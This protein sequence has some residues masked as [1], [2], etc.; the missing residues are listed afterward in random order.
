MS[1][2]NTAKRR[3]I[4]QLEKDY[5]IKKKNKVQYKKKVKQLQFEIERDDKLIKDDRK[6]KAKEK[7]DIKNEVTQLFKSA[8]NIIK[9]TTKKSNTQRFNEYVNNL[10][11]V[12]GLNNRRRRIHLKGLGN[13]FKEIYITEKVNNKEVMRKVLFQ[14]VNKE[15]EEARNNNKTLM[16]YFEFKYFMIDDNGIETTRYSRN[17]LNDIPT[18]NSIE[19]IINE[20]YNKLS[21][22]L[23]IAKNNSRLQFS[24]ISKITIRTTR[25]QRRVGGDY[26]ESPEGVQN[27]TS[28]INIKNFDNR[29]LEYCILAS[30]H[31]NDV[32]VN[33]KR[34]PNV[35]KKYFNELNIPENQK[36]PIDIIED[37]PKYE[38]LNKLRIMIYCIRDK[39]FFPEYRS[40]S[41]HNETLNLLLLEEGDKKHFIW[42]RNITRI[43]NHLSF[44]KNHKR[45]DCDNCFAKS[46]K[47]QEKLD[48]HQKLCLNNKRC[49]VELPIKGK[50]EMKFIHDC[51][52]FKHPFDV[53]ADFES[54]LLKVNKRDDEKDEVEINDKKKKKKK[55]KATFAYQKHVPNSCGLKYNC[56]HDIHSEKIKIINDKNPQIVCDKWIYELERLAKKS[57]LLTQQHK[58]NI[59]WKEGEKEKHFKNSNC[60]RCKVQYTEKNKRV[61]HHNHITGDFLNSFC[62]ECNLKY[63]YKPFLP[64]YL[65]NLKGYDS[66]LFI[67]SL[68][69]CGYQQED[70]KDII[71][72]I[73][74]NEERYIS[75]SKKIKVVE[76]TKNNK[77]VPI[78]YEIRFIDTFAF[79]ASSIDALSDNLKKGCKS[80]NELR[81]VFKNISEEFDNDE[82]FNLIIKK[83]VY[84]YDYID[85]YERLNEDKLP[86]Q[87]NFYSKLNNQ[88]CNDD[89]YERAKLVWKTFKCK[90]LIDYHNVY[91]KSDVLLLSDIW[92]N[93]RE[94]CYK[95]Y[96]LDCTYY[97]TAPSLS[98]D[99]MM[100][101]TNIKFELLTDIDMVNFVES[102]IR[103]GLSQISKRHAEANN[104]YMKTYEK[105]KEDSYITYLDANNLY[106][107][108][109]SEYLPYKSFKWNKDIWTR[110]KILDLNDKGD[111]GY[112][113]AVDLHIPVKLHDYFNGYTPLP[114]NKSIKKKDLNEWQ[115][116]DYNETKVEKLCCSLEDRKDYVVNY[117]MLKLALSLGY[118][119]KN[120]N[121]VLEYEQ[122]PF[123]KEYIDL[124]TNLRTKA[125]NDF[126]KDF[127]KLMNNSV[128]GKTMENVKNRIEFRLLNNEGQVDRLQSKM[129]NFT[130]FDDN[131]VGVHLQKSKVV[132][133]KPIYIGQNVLDDSK[134]T[135]MNFHYNFMKKHIK[136]E[137]LSLLFTDTDSLCY[138][139]K[140][141]DIYEK[142]QNNKKYFDLSNYPK[143][144]FLYDETNKKVV[145]MF[146][147]E[148]IKEIKEFI[149]LRSKLYSY[150][151]DDEIE[152]KRCKGVKKS[153]VKKFI[154]H[155]NYKNTLFKRDDF[156]VS[157]NGIRSYNHQ[158]YSET[159]M[160]VALSA[161]DDKVYIENNNI[162]TLTHGHYKINNK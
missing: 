120:V 48:E 119:L 128:F 46:F 1:T 9:P 124:N 70:N 37:V 56:I 89:D 61:A 51:Y 78:M 44:D 100:K 67:K 146:K 6:K 88:D 7:R 8:N 91:L 97:Y 154:K 18:V 64:V 122:K 19:M 14:K 50:N 57:Y 5:N 29:C 129:N 147:N 22:D 69:S 24:H 76:Y 152:H 36:Y 42:I 123:L 141:E 157:Q 34:N 47:T 81:K 99:A 73:P 133:N 104:K 63:Q 32:S 144:H 75:F 53:E 94:V 110:E 26:I 108:A 116:K 54:T 136:D 41:K 38:E 27:S 135:M 153:V 137:N 59:L 20:A 115:Q 142:I 31:F 40:G 109:M 15:L 85:N 58:Y 17:L 68:Y 49:K 45:Y 60:E 55:K 21:A 130:I 11:I 98:W 96:K 139:I 134:Y 12:E 126:E 102:G 131:L 159:T 65:H 3:Y 140:K 72:C 10:G 118:E 107:G 83:G 150:L 161:Y 79:M 90:K 80:T 16:V 74:N 117:R 86:N 127:Y 71:S 35:Y 138:H 39:L 111:K 112:L 125:N 13:A 43:K 160:K 82:E 114:I 106:G 23:E 33:G 87:K 145:N 132:M 143:E 156:I 162:D 93:F 113:F 101:K 28:T 149:G 30:R 66:H 121:K 52:E 62:N 151:T 158:L 155:E 92:R 105:S 148:S 84:P 4:K 25:K 2:L 103:G 77:T 95:N